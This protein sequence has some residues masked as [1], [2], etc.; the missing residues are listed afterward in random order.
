MDASTLLENETTHSRVET[1]TCLDEN[2]SITANPYLG[3]DAEASPK[4]Q[5]LSH[6]ENQALVQVVASPTVNS[7]SQSPAEILGPPITHSTSHKSTADQ[8]ETTNKSESNQEIEQSSTKR[9][10]S[11]WHSWTWKVEIL[12]WL[13]SLGCFIAIFVFLRVLDHRPLPSLRYGITPNAIIGLLA[14]FVQILLLVPVTSSIGQLK[15]LRALRRRPIY[16]F[17]ALDRA[18][19]GPWGSFLLLIRGSGG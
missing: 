9:L 3:Q 1:G 2:D 18:S 19:R 10:Q 16:T 8:I 7:P 17:Q 14:S 13:G 12:G 11:V 4:P 5:R 6:D 15:W